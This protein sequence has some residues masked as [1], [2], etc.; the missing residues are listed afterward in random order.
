MDTAIPSTWPWVHGAL[1]LAHV[2]SV[3]TTGPC[4]ESMFTERLNGTTPWAQW[5]RPPHPTHSPY[6]ASLSQ[7][8]E[9]HQCCPPRL[10]QARLPILL[11]YCHFHQESHGNRSPSYTFPSSMF[12][13]SGLPP[14]VSTHWTA[15]VRATNNSKHKY[16]L[17]ITI[18]HS[19]STQWQF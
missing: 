13:G 17:K 9:A 12:G 4:T 1:H 8:L 15:S 16:G 2:F 3:D 11:P 5:E 6:V 10:P 19:D 7:N 18:N 14:H